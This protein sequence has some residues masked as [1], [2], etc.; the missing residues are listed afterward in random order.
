MNRWLAAIQTFDCEFEHVPAERH[1]GP[2]GLSRRGCAEDDS[3]DSDAELDDDNSFN[4]IR[5]V[6]N[7]ERGSI[8][9]RAEVVE[10]EDFDELHVNA[11]TAGLDMATMREFQGFYKDESGLFDIDI[12]LFNDRIE[13]DDESTKMFYSSVA[14]TV[15]HPEEG[16]V[17]S[18]DILGNSKFDNDEEWNIWQKYQIASRMLGES[19]VVRSI[20]LSKI[21]GYGEGTRRNYPFW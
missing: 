1:K 15:E 16:D 8:L 12:G 10:L 11:N 2:D 5:V 21:T 9:Q 13:G 4:Y 6:K 17:T 7:A 18:M 14:E 3:D 19:R 20:S